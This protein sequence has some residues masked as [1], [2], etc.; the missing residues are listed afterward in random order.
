M[1]IH[2]FSPRSSEPAA[3][4]A[5]QAVTAAGSDPAEPEGGSAGAVAAFRSGSFLTKLRAACR[6]MSQPVWPPWLDAALAKKLQFKNS[7]V[8]AGFVLV[9]FSAPGWDGS[10]LAPAC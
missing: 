6:S 4:A 8:S 1:A 7:S 3:V 2:A 10:V 5:G 9:S